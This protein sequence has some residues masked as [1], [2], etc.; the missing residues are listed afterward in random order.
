MLYCATQPDRIYTAVVDAALTEA[1]GWATDPHRWRTHAPHVVEGFPAHEAPQTALPK[2]QAAHRKI[3]VYRMSHFFWVVLYDVLSAY[4]N[5]H[6]AHS[7]RTSGMQVDLMPMIGGFRCG[8][9]RMASILATFWW[10]LDCFPEAVRDR[11]LVLPPV[12]HRIRGGAER[13]AP[14]VPGLVEITCPQWARNPDAAELRT[15]GM[16]VP[17][18]PLFIASAVVDTW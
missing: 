6:N 9:L 8:P 3:Q 5:R 10:D 14:A 13:Y 2:L 1:R 4:A 16:T 7:R 11:T 15:P 12:S 17:H 18:Y